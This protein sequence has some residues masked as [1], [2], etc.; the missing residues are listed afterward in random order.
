MIHN[1]AEQVYGTCTPGTPKL[2]DYDI[3]SNY[4]SDHNSFNT[5]FIDYKYTIV[6]MIHES[7]DNLSFYQPGL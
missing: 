2:S 3:P 4:T 5:I 7:T 6:T 1:L